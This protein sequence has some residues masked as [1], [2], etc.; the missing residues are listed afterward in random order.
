MIYTPE[1]VRIQGDFAVFIGCET[2]R[3]ALRL[4][5]IESVKAKY[6]ALDRCWELTVRMDSCMKHR[7]TFS[8]IG[9]VLELLIGGADS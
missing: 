1:N 2:E 3:L 5:S 9:N 4:T 7:F 6:C 8:T